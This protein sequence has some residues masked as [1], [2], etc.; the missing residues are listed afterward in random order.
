MGEDFVYSDA[1][2]KQKVKELTE[3]IKAEVLAVDPA[4]G[5]SSWIPRYK[6]V[7]Q[8]TM[9]ERKDQDVRVTSRCLWDT[10]TDNYASASMQNASTWISVVV[11]GMY[12]E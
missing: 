4:T 7:V 9:G 2:C 12:T 10:E 1:G 5:T 11:F 8:V 6:V 3:L